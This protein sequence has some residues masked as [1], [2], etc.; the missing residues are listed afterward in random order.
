MAIYSQSPDGNRVK[1]GC[2]ASSINN[3]IVVYHCPIHAAAPEL[4][5]ALKDIIETCSV[6]IDD[7]RIVHFDKARALI[8]QIEGEA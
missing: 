6:R 7:P 5:A 3:D 8:A 2:S 4:L 1:C